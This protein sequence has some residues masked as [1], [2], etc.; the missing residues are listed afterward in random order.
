MNKLVGSLEAVD[1][2]S[3][4]LPEKNLQGL[5]ITTRD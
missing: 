5:K 2:S 4:I 1:L 3:P